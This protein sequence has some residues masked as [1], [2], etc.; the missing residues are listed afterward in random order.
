MQKL[1]HFSSPLGYASGVPKK[2]QTIQVDSPHNW[3]T[4]PIWSNLWQMDSQNLKKK[5]K[6]HIL[7]PQKSSRNPI[8]KSSPNPSE[9]PNLPNFS[10]HESLRSNPGSGPT[11]SASSCEESTKSAQRGRAAAAAMGSLR[12]SRFFRLRLLQHGEIFVLEQRKSNMNIW[13]R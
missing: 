4:R 9:I 10:C 2:D 1:P 7:S 11:T 6:H 13:Y 5:I 8:P 3:W 12:R